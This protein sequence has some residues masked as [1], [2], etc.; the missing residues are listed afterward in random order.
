MSYRQILYW[1]W[2][3]E[4][5][6]DGK[7]LRGIDDIARRSVFDTIYVALTWCRPTL[8]EPAGH[9]A[10]AAAAKRAHSHGIDFM[11]DIDVRPARRE[12]FRRYPDRMLGMIGTIEVVLDSR[13]SAS[14][15]TATGPSGDHYGV[16]HPVGAR[17][18]RAYAFREQGAGLER[19][20]IT[21]ITA[22]CA[23]KQLEPDRVRVNITCGPN[24]AEMRAL[25]FVAFEYDY[26]DIFSN[27]LIDFHSELLDMYADVPLDGVTIDEWGAF[28]YPDFD[29]SGAWRRPW[30]SESLARR[31]ERKTGRDIVLDFLYTRIPPAGDSAAQINAINDYYALLRETNVEIERFFYDSV[32]RIWG[33]D[34]FVGVHPTW[35]AIEELA[36]TPEIWKNGIDWWDVPRDFGQTDEIMLY[37]VRTALAHKCGG[38]V[39]F[40]MWYGM[41]TGNV[42]TFWSEAW[43]NLRWGGRT[44]TLSYECKAETSAVTELAPPGLLESV[45]EIEELVALA[46]LFQRAAVK[47]NVLVVMGY[48]AVI[49]WTVNVEDGVHWDIRRGAFVDCFHVANEVFKAGYVCDLVPSYEIDDGDLRF[50]DGHLT[51]GTETYDALIYVRPEF[52]TPA[53]LNFLES[54]LT[55]A[56]FPVALLGVCDLDSTGAD[57]S[58]RFNKLADAVALHLDAI[59]PREVIAVLDCW[60]IKRNDI[61]DGSRL[62][63]GSVIICNRGPVHRGNALR[64]ENVTVNGHKVDA[65]CQ[66]A[67]GIKLDEDGAIQRLF[68]GG[69][70]EVRVDG[71]LVLRIPQPRDIY[72]ERT[73]AGYRAADR[74]GR[75]VEWYD[76]PV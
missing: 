14:G 56:G 54:L 44:H 1:K 15:E 59:D 6:I 62:Q 27:E 10:I 3:D 19:D 61:P 55:D 28:P 46:N 49:N 67:F 9:E 13:G 50:A 4:D 71:N 57:A 65:L 66:D 47:S 72:V 36:N 7:Y 75:F 40:N 22:S 23:L 25:A 17:L 16:Y 51:Y 41:G 35:F 31:Y 73:P 26:P 70:S 39:F 43:E 38:A 20:S 29:F 24:M 52:S 63:D 64:L 74:G 37:P 69:L 48:P 34:T 12:F 30:Y 53:S 68:A 21:D 11:F 2:D 8:N 58:M 60:G 42:K 18:V 33:Q 76:L 32:K 5:F 45:S